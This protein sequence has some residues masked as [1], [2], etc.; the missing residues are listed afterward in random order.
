MALKFPIKIFYVGVNLLVF[1]FT[2]DLLSGGFKDYGVKWI[3][4]THLNH[5]SAFNFFEVDIPKPGNVP[6]PSFRLCE[7]QEAVMDVRHISFNKNRKFGEIL[8]NFLYQYVLIFLW[9]LMV[10]SLI[11]SV[12]GV[13]LFC[14]GQLITQACSIRGSNFWSR[15]GN[16]R[17]CEY[18]RRKN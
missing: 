4:W 14:F 8:P 15:V 18:L 3:Q 17:E 11:L 1:M 6:L 13:L 5:S 16:L 10:S 12:I 7:I 2:D 9:F